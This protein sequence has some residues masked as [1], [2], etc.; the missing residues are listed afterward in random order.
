MR[1][2]AGGM[3]GSD[4]IGKTLSHYKILEKLGEGGMGVVYLADD[5]RLGRRIALKLLPAEWTRSSKA[6]ARFLHEAQTAAALNHPNL[7]TIHEVDEADG[8]VFIA[9]EHIEGESL[10]DKIARGPMKIADV[11]VAG[12]EVGQGLAAA[13]ALGIVHRDVK[14]GNVMLTSDG[15]AKVLD[16][17]LALAPERTRLTMAGRTT[18]TVSYMSPEQSRGEAVDHRTDIWSLGVMLYE[19]LTGVRPFAGEHE[20]AVI[21]SIVNDEPEPPTGL[22]TGIPLE[23]ERVVRKAMAKSPDERYQHVDDL[24]VD[25]RS[26]QREA[27]T[28]SKTVTVA[29]QTGR[30]ATPAARRGP[31]VTV[32]V[33][34]AVAI[35]LAGVTGYT[36]WTRGRQEATEPTGAERVMVATF[37][38]RTGDPALDYI[39]HTA[40]TSI[41][42][43]VAQTGIAEVVTHAAEEPV[44]GGAGQNVGATS[45]LLAVAREAG[46]SV[47]VAGS[48]DVQS[49]SLHIE[50]RLL[51]VHDGTVLNVIPDETGP[52]VTPAATIAKTRSR[53]MGALAMRADPTIGREGRSHAPTYEAYQEYAA[54]MG[55]FGVDSALALEHFERA[56]EL[57]PA[58]VP[59][60]TIQLGAFL[61]L[62]RYAE[63]DSLIQ[64]IRSRPVDLTPRSRLFVDAIAARLEGNREGALRKLRELVRAEPEHWWARRLLAITALTNNRPREAIDAFSALLE[65]GP[66]TNTYVEAWTYSGLASCYHILGEFEQE[67]EVARQ[68]IEAFPDALWLRGREVRAL[69]GLGRVEEIERIIE[70]SASTAAGSGSV[71]GVMVTAIDEL[72]AHGYAEESAALAEEALQWQRNRMT[73]E[74]SPTES[75]RLA[76]ALFRTK[77]WEE[78]QALYEEFALADPDNLDDQGYVGVLAARMGDRERALD[79]KRTLLARDVPY[80]FGMDTYWAACIAAQLGEREEAMDLLRRSFSEGASIGLHIHQDPDLEPLWDYPPFQRLLEPRG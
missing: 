6:R 68:A 2:T 27:S 13:H 41:S 76:Q 4:L 47:L 32:L 74:G 14:P 18:G 37:D 35:V 70:K 17:G 29:A 31:S 71:W 56:L 78:A 19:M 60:R 58:F 65:Q 57:D 66:Q 72:K 16:F 28:G 10:R 80:E 50:A 8:Q 61:M 20:Q 55:L 15:R 43:G 38:N 5:T 9:M 75:R 79:V 73:I 40:A 53:V 39:G 44:A 59:A 34:W 67:L 64:H 46:A 62:D 69:A 23:L 54:G 25:L 11:I 51:D 42:E 1:D 33:I 26:V 52:L 77:H 63:A 12:L 48:F 21:R 49:D 45:R 22:R 36:M 7:C 30:T 24:L 3:M